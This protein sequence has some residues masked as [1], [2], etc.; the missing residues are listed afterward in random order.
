M[1]PLNIQNERVYF[2]DIRLEHLPQIL[3]W[4]NKVDDFKFAT[5]I[6]KT[7]TIDLLTKKY[8]E[9]AICSEEFF[10]GVFLKKEEKMIGILKGRLDHE[11]KNVVWIS[12]IVIDT[13]YQNKGYGKSVIELLLSHFKRNNG[14]ENAYL[15]VIEEN[16]QGRGFWTS[17]NFQEVRRIENHIKLQERQQNIIIMYK[18]I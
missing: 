11:N 12:S 10:T 17:Q 2:R 14:I 16:I 3:D 5:G 6:D 4:Y 9:V 8:A 18:K 1:L 15:S 7:I 13:N